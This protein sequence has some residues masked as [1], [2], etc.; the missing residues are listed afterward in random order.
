MTNI[1]VNGASHVVDLKIRDGSLIRAARVPEAVP[2]HCPKIFLFAERGTEEEWLGGGAEREAMYGANTFSDRS[3]FYTHTTMI[4]NVV[5]A[6]GNVCM[7]K[8]LVPHDAGPAANYTLWV[9]LLETTV[10]LYRRNQDGSLAMVNGQPEIIGTT[11]GFKRKIVVTTESNVELAEQT[12]GVKTQTE[13][14]QVD[15]NNPTI[16]SIR[17]PILER[18]ASSRGAWGN[19]IGDRLWG[20]D[21]RT[22]SVPERLMA[23][24]RAFP[25]MLQTVER[26]TR[27][28]STKVLQTVM[29]DQNMLFTFK[30]GSVDPSTNKDVYLADVFG[31]TYENEDPRYPLQEAALNG[32]A[33]YQDN[34]DHLLTILHQAEAPYIDPEFHDFTASPE[35]KYL[36]NLFGGCTIN[37]YQYH[38]YLPVEGTQALNRYET[39]YAGGGSD[40]TMNL[41][42]LEAGVVEQVARYADDYDGIQDK[43]FHVENNLY[44]SGF[45]LPTKLALAPFVALRGDT[46]I[47]FSTFQQ[48]E[49]S[50]DNSEELSI[51]QAI[52]ARM[53]NLPESTWF[54]TAVV[55]A[56]IYGGDCE[57]RNGRPGVR[58]ST[59]AE[60]AHKRAKYMGSSNGKWKNGNQYD[61]GEPGSLA[62]ITTKFSK[63]WV[64]VKVRYRFW[65]AG[66]N[67]WGRM[68][69]SQAYCPAFR[70]IYEHEASV[71]TAD[72]VVQALL[73][74]NKCNERSHRSH[75][76]TVGQSNAVF[77]K[78][79]VE[80]LQALGNADRFDNRF[81][82]NG[83]AEVTESDMAR[84]AI[85]W[86]SGY[87]LYADA[88]RTVALNY[89]E[90]FRRTT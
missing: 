58:V 41:E 44:D 37:G 40:G 34:I 77:T 15:P 84:G 31:P 18:K 64:P 88:M 2:Q 49:R 42:T 19:N 25:Y 62:E 59:V 73:E 55:R 38:T 23:V 6:Q 87:Q 57:L 81:D 48:G 17:F 52:K 4:S 69:R 8:R 76:G 82:I 39:L 83:V 28:H 51:A 13:G 21:G 65:D 14:D 70:T 72:T 9:D 68:D 7:Y 61:Q 43:L 78:R 11:R 60:V 3:K 20:V 46:F 32:L 54:G 30:P 74:L 53:T 56:A 36:F 22:D 63:L 47:T 1:V 26:D 50:F 12:F 10:D 89:S 80:K 27:L 35:D 66:L 16:R 75:S 71:L 29:G 86:H 5:N 85:S 45:S 33:V 90:V 79:V 24:E 67:W